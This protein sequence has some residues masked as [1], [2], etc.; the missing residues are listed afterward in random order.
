MKIHAYIVCWDNVND[1]VVNNIERQFIDF[2]QPHTI[3][4]SGNIKNDRWDNVGDIRYY[5]QFHK[6]LKDFDRSNDYMMFICGDVS[7]SNWAG[8]LERTAYVLEKYSN[9]YAYAPH[10]TNDPWNEG[11]TSLENIGDDLMISSN[12]NGIMFVLHKDVVEFM[13]IYM[14]YL[15]KKHK[16]STMISGWGIDIVWSAYAIYMNRIVLRDSKFIVTHPA[17]STYDHGKATSETIAVMDTFLEFSETLGFNLDKIKSISSKISGRMSKA[18]D[19]MLVSDFYDTYPELIK[20]IDI[21]Y[22]I[23]SINDE[24]KENKD[25]IDKIL[26]GNKIDI[27]SLNARD[28]SLV[29]QFHIDNPEFKFGW[30]TFKPGEFGNFGSHY[31]AWK[32]LINSSMDNL[33]VFEDD[34]LISEDFIE[35]YTTAINNTPKDF[36][37]LSIYV[38]PNQYPRYHSSDYINDYISKG[39]Q[40][41]STLCYVV[42]RQGATKMLDYVLHNGMDYPTDWF[43]F[44]NGHK[45]IFNVYTLLPNFQPPLKIDTRYESQVQ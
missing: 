42:S 6:A 33:L 13:L 24:R 1:N 44:R 40:D 28:E 8:V 16:L 29:S 38:D 35:K 37:V 19:C 23:I 5:R 9:T 15:D 20:K 45:G 25:L 27:K 39:Y 2:N 30:D 4:N 18:P 21:N 43:I 31:I 36:D 12:T 41:W 3:I 11:S 14:D 26:S 7:H 17:G 10:F 34:A 32:H 22:H